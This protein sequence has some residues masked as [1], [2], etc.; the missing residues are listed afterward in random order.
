LK[1]AGLGVLEIR[2][3]YDFDGVDKVAIETNNA[4]PSIAALADPKQATA[5]QRPARFI[6]VEKA[7]E[8]PSKDVRKVNYAAFGA[9]A[10]MRE[11]LAYA[12][13]EPDGS[14]K[15]ELPANVPFTIEILDKNARRLL[16]VGRHTSW[17][18]LMPGETKT[19]TGC[20]D[21]TNPA[22]PAFPLSHGRAGLTKSVYAGAS[23]GGAVFA[24]TVTSLPAANAGDT[25]AETRAWNT[26]P[27]VTTTTCAEIP[28]IDVHYTDFWTDAAA[29]GRPADKAFNY[30]YSDLSTPSPAN[31]HCAP[32]SGLCRSTIH[33]PDDTMPPYHIQSI[34][35]FARIAT[36]NALPVDH[37]CVTCHTPIGAAAAIQIPAGDL[38][39]RAVASTVNTSVSTSYQQLLFPRDAQTLIM[40]VPTPTGVVLPPAMTAGSANNSSVDFF[41]L[42]DGGFVPP[43][44]TDHTGF[45]TTAELRL[46]TEWIDIG[47]Q[48]YN[49]PFVAPAAN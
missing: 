22:N 27:T 9:N 5:I 12:P 26:C 38:D 2:S 30:L 10:G 23:A 31:A 11:I 44:G 24:N 49:D 47:A 16:G 48:Y 46:I 41:R 39:L 18:Q 21:P 17:L 6:R 43:S 32:W 8:I 34:W 45:L 37:T 35:D 40:N 29:A 36:M 13:I 33:Y 19:C 14:V 28:S 4:V 20:H 7:V 15:L 3:V 1:G 42:F 25:M